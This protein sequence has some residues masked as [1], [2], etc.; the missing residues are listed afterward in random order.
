VRASMCG[1][2]A[3]AGYGSGASSKAMRTAP[4]FQ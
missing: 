4:L 1:S 2:S 3:F